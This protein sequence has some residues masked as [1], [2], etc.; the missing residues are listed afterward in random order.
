MQRGLVDVQNA[1]QPVRG[2]SDSAVLEVRRHV[3]LQLLAVERLD[4]AAAELS[5]LYDDLVRI[6]G[7]G[8]AATAEVRDA[9]ITLRR[10]LR[11]RRPG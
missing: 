1:L 3:A 6:H 7:G 11:G 8:A 4:E 9:L 10:C 2:D 5:R